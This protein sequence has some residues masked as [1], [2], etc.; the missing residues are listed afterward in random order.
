L[1][2]VPACTW[3]HC[4]FLAVLCG[5]RSTASEFHLVAQ[6]CSFLPAVGLLLV[7][8]SLQEARE[9]K[10]EA[11]QLRNQLAAAQMERAETLSM[12]THARALNEALQTQVGVLLGGRVS[13][14]E[15]AG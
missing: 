13:G 12:L 2:C 4:G 5:L 3:Q 14:R 10:V 1:A 15:M 7:G 8:C 9:A 11:S 6:A